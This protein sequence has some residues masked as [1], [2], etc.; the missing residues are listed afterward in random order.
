M[1]VKQLIEKLSAYDPETM[2]IRSGYEG[3][4]TEVT[5]IDKR[6]IKLNVNHQWWYG[7]HEIAIGSDPFDC[8]AIYIV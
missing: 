2:V 6:K 3:G 4:V 5:E 8:E 1:N 7:K